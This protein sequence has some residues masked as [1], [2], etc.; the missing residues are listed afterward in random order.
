MVIY[1]YEFPITDSFTLD[2][3]VGAKVLT[4]FVQAENPQWVRDRKACL[5]AEVNPDI[6]MESRKFSIVGT[7]NPM[8]HGIKRWIASFPDGQ[9][10]WHL[11]EMK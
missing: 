9:F 11:Y 3:P 5:W 1:K 6:I 10:V 4:A 2:L 7:G 8:P